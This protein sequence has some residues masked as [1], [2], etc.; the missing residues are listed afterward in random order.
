MSDVHPSAQID[1]GAR[2]GV[3]VRIGAFAVVGPGVELG[4]GVVL[5]PHTVVIGNTQIGARTQVFP[6]A[7]VGGAPQD[8]SFAGEPTRLEIGVDNVIREHVTV[9]LGTPRGGGCTRLG[10]DN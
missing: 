1:P 5:H 6:F 3:G 4:D 2:L 8:K 9:H 10:D 7:A